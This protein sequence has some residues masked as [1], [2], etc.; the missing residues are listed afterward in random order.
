M[1]WATFGLK[2]EDGYWE[3]MS[4]NSTF[5]LNGT[6][7]MVWGIIEDYAKNHNHLTNLTGTIQIHPTLYTCAAIIS[8]YSTEPGVEPHSKS[9]YTV[10]RLKE[11]QIFIR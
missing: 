6:Q 1:W 8:W 3:I 11:R 2:N 10:V 9:E 5:L 4:V 7:V